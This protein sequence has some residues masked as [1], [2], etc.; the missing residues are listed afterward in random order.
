M[1]RAL[2]LVF[3]LVV[4]T[5]GGY[6]VYSRTRKTPAFPASGSAAA[7][8]ATEEDTAAADPASAPAAAARA[9]TAAMARLGVP[10]GAPAT[11]N[12][13]E[14]VT[15]PVAPDDHD[16]E[17]QFP[18]TRFGGDS[19]DYADAT[20]DEALTVAKNT[21]T[22]PRERQNAVLFLGEKMGL[23][24]WEDLLSVEM[25]EKSPKVMKAVAMAEY[26]VRE[27]FAG[28]DWPGVVKSDPSKYLE[29]SQR[30]PP[31]GTAQPAQAPPPGAA[32]K[33]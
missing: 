7:A 14:A 10:A 5:A 32:P 17:N 16:P 26:R 13:A 18:K 29:E 24:H 11:P 2:L 3:G 25:T 1:K 4:V 23:D 15:I 22:T 27:R 31:P 20:V 33:P 6:E 21:A 9:R 12:A 30:P 8:G 19:K 28:H